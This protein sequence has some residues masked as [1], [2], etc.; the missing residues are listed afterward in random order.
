MKLSLRLILILGV[1]INRTS[2]KRYQD[3]VSEV[4]ADRINRRLQT[5]NCTP[6]VLFSESSQTRPTDHYG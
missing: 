3:F 4:E 5:E 2:S 6:I 1:A